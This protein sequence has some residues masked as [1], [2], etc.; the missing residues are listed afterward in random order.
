MHEA[1]GGGLAFERARLDHGAG[2]GFHHAAADRVQRDRAGQPGERGGEDFR[3]DGHERESRGGTEL[4]DYERDAVGEFV[5]ELGAGE[6]DAHLKPEIADEEIGELFELKM[7]GTLEPQEEQRSEVVHD[8]L[9]D[10]AD[11]AGVHGVDVAV[12]NAHDGRLPVLVS[13]P[14]VEAEASSVS[15][16]FSWPNRKMRRRMRR[17]WSRTMRALSRNGRKCVTRFP[18]GS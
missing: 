16:I 14:S 1:H 8:G 18:G 15:S 3:Q 6:R 5:G 4:P 9:R 17:A 10:V 7:V 13:A 2:D 12:A 11:V